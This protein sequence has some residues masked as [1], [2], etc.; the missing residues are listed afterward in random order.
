MKEVTKRAIYTFVITIFVVCLIVL[1][2]SI[3]KKEN[4]RLITPTSVAQVKTCVI[5][6]GFILFKY[7]IKK[8][9]WYTMVSKFYIWQ[10]LS[11]KIRTSRKQNIVFFSYFF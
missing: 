4:T 10:D 5:D 11:V 9:F 3:Y 7:S 8:F 6:A 1:G 2:W